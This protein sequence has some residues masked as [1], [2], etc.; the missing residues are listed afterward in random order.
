MKKTLVYTNDIS[1][2]EFK[3]ML[4]DYMTDEEVSSM[5]YDELYDRM[6]EYLDDEHR[7]VCADLNVQY[8]MPI[9][10]VADLGLWNG[11]H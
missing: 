6:S 10:V 1:S 7:R 2:E 3:E 11:R 8:N 4:Q 9:L 5:S